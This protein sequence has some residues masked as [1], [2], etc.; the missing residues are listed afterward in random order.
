MDMYTVEITD[1]KG[2]QSWMYTGISRWYKPEYL[3]EPL[4][5]YRKCNPT[6]QFKLIED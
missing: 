5:Y 2:Y 6:K 1:E 4:E 3:E